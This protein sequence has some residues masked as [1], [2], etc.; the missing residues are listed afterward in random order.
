MR[1][2]LTAVI[3]AYACVASAVEGP[4]EER[5]LLDRSSHWSSS[6]HLCPHYAADVCES[7]TC[8]GGVLV[9]VA[10][11]FATD[12]EAIDRVF[13]E[14]RPAG[15]KA[16]LPVELGPGRYLASH[17]LLLESTSK[18]VGRTIDSEFQVLDAPLYGIGEHTGIEGVVIVFGESAWEAAVLV[19]GWVERRAFAP[20]GATAAEIA[21]LVEDT[22]KQS[23]TSMY[24]VDFVIWVRPSLADDSKR[25]DDPGDDPA[26]KRLLK[27]ALE[28]SLPP[29]YVWAETEESD[30]ARAARHIIAAPERCGPVPPRTTPSEPVG[31]LPV[32]GK[33]ASNSV[34]NVRQTGPRRSVRRDASRRSS[35][36]PRMRGSCLSA[37]PRR[38]SASKSP[39]PST[40]QCAAPAVM[41]SG[42][43]SNPSGRPQETQRGRFVDGNCDVA[44]LARDWAQARAPADAPFLARF[45][46]AAASAALGEAL[47]SPHLYVGE[48]AA[49]KHHCAV[50]RDTGP[51]QDFWRRQ[52]FG[53][54]RKSVHVSHT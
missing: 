32:T 48:A 16:P 36:A 4:L 43:P 25:R 20:L 8:P 53:Q 41:E 9:C 34:R 33:R 11:D 54:R 26:S 29:H 3:F 15:D 40:I 6:V 44:Q 28:P 38:T 1:P 13:T 52:T 22:V 42:T 10:I 35:S 23:S 27:R 51:I 39:A 47:L 7:S 5:C 31:G 12:V 17:W 19:D 30:A 18:R 49:P 45:V 50:Y 14:C 24:E 2:R 37:R 21:Q 46:S